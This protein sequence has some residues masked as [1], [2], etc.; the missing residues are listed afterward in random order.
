MP[1][2]RAAAKSTRKQSSPRRPRRSALRTSSSLAS[3]PQ[4]RLHFE[5]VVQHHISRRKASTPQE[6][7]KFDE[8]LIGDTPVSIEPADIEGALADIHSAPH[9]LCAVLQRMRRTPN[10]A[11]SDEETNDDESAPL[12]EGASDADDTDSKRKYDGELLEL[13][14]VQQ[15]AQVLVNDVFIENESDEV[16]LF[17]ACILAEI[18]RITAPK[19]PLSDSK[20]KALCAL[21][22]DELSVIA[23][24]RDHLRSFRFSLLEQLASVKTFVIFA[25]EDNVA[26][27]IFACFYA[28]VRPHQAEKYK[29]HLGFILITLLEE[30]KGI[31]QSLLD[32][33]L[34]PLT[35]ASSLN[36]DTLD[37]AL[38]SLSS[39]SES[40]LS[41]SEYVIKGAKN[42]LQVPI[43]NFFNA[44]LHRLSK[45]RVLPENPSTPPRRRRTA[46]V[47]TS[48]D[49]DYETDGKFPSELSEDI[50]NLVIAVNQIAPEI[51]I[52]VIP[53]LEDRLLAKDAVVRRNVAHLLGKLFMSSAETVKAYPSL[54]TEY[55]QRARDVDPSLRAEVCATL[56]PLIVS[57]PRQRDILNKRLQDRVLDQSELVREIVA[58]S[59]GRTQSYASTE[60][61]KTLTSRLRDRKLSVRRET[62]QQ[63]NSL[64]RAQLKL[65]PKRNDLSDPATGNDTEDEVKDAAS[66]DTSNIHPGTESMSI[67]QNVLDPEL[68]KAADV[69]AWAAELPKLLVSTHNFMQHTDDLVLVNGIE[70]SIFEQFYSWD[71]IHSSDD[72]LRVR[73]IAAFLGNLDAQ[74]FVHFSSMLSKRSRIAAAL[75]RICEIRL[76]SRNAV[77]RDSEGPS[78]RKRTRSELGTPVRE[79]K[80]TFSKRGQSSTAKQSP[81]ENS[82]YELNGELRT[83]CNS[84]SLLLGRRKFRNENSSDLCWKMCNFPDR[85]FYE[86]LKSVLI[87]SVSCRAALAV[88]QDAVSRLSSKSALGEFVASVVLPAARC[89]MFSVRHVQA[90]YA[91]VSAYCD[92][93]EIDEDKVL[94]GDTLLREDAENTF[95]KENDIL[96]GVLRFIDLTSLHLPATFVNI[97]YIPCGLIRQSNHNALSVTQ[98]LLCGLKAMSRVDCANLEAT[99]REPLIQQLRTI[100]I[101]PVIAD[102]KVSSLLAKW[103]SRAILQLCTE[104][105]KSGEVLKTTLSMLLRHLKTYSSDALQL[106][107]AITAL[108]QLAKHAPDAF[109]LNAFQTFD[110][111]RSLL[112]G[113]NNESLRENFNEASD[114]EGDQGKTSLFRSVWDSSFPPSCSSCQFSCT[115]VISDLYVASL[116]E[117]AHRGMKLLV[118]ALHAIDFDEDD[119]ANVVQLMNHITEVK[120][121]DIFGLRKKIFIREEDG[122]EYEDDSDTHQNPSVASACNVIRLSASSTILNLARSS[123]FFRLVTPADFRCAVLCAQDVNPDVRISFVRNLHRYVLRKGLPFRWIA[124]LALMAVD[125]DKDNVTEVRNLL[126]SALRRR[127]NLIKVKMQTSVSVPRKLLPEATVPVLLWLLGNHPDAEIEDS[128]YESSSVKCMEFLLDRLL[129][130]NDYAAIVHEYLDAMAVARDK[131]E[132]EDEPGPSTERI[133]MLA[134]TC[135]IILKKK[136]AGRKWNLLEHPGSVELP[137]DLFR[138]EPSNVQNSAAIEPSLLDAAKRYDADVSPAEHSTPQAHGSL[139]S[140]APGNAIES[141]FAAHATGTPSRGRDRQVSSKDVRRTIDQITS[142]PRLSTSSRSSEQEIAQSA[143]SGSSRPKRRKRNTVSANK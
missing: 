80:K 83:V 115:D 26:T 61:I 16:R 88:G 74:S 143:D 131:T 77:K 53:S 70:R 96:C 25:D 22:V 15:L 98:V 79:S 132:D 133:R 87:P 67:E 103:A 64:Y 8:K 73:Q 56:G 82:P 36:S 129:D 33:L 91:I 20:L 105:E 97:T 34:A 106:V 30:V 113:N 92:R 29:E 35:R 110:D 6:L 46:R 140:N 81:S 100:M 48:D 135:T 99:E 4:R 32:A 54:F 23:F 42:M 127:R 102:A 114:S 5:R 13:E 58:V 62:F 142:S 60:L 17:T 47:T 120:K 40:A 130:S 116:A 118:Y 3:L 41:L 18:L 138:K 28:S 21:F 136:Q 7:W 2:P 125:P 38:K 10:I 124:A 90:A 78:P 93:V 31:N 121:G 137:G 76:N 43:C 65:I 71:L 122:T 95:A 107:N 59:V 123:R 9:I 141:P 1:L 24:P 75:L 52:Y 50:E 55:L 68:K 101:A 39:Y 139:L 14:D 109:K 104:T 19:P 37:P 111:V 27:D 49:P 134:R 51:L 72:D 89:L 85:R 112:W 11:S 86:Q 66:E 108:G 45:G 117:L 57:T 119:V 128:D 84:L 69:P 44:A 63:L 94:N 126:I 12:A